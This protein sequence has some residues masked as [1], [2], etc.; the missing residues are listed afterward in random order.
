MGPESKDAVVRVLGHIIDELLQ[1]RHAVQ[2][3][4]SAIEK[5]RAD[6]IADNVQTHRRIAA[7]ERKVNG[8]GT[9]PPAAAE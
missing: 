9:T 5:D 8:N 6:T 2:G 3:I 7:I 1:L 4:K